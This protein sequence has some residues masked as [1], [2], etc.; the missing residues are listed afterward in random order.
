MWDS[1][2]L[3]E[4]SVKS[5]TIKI[6]ALAVVTAI[7]AACASSKPH[8]FGDSG[9][10]NPRVTPQKGERVPQHLTLQLNQGANVAVFLVVPGRGSELLFPA[11]SIQNAYVD[12]GSHIVTTRATRGML[13][14]TSRLMRMPRG[15][16]QPMGGGGRGQMNR[17]SLGLGIIGGHG[18][19]LMY[20]S[21]QAL[22]YDILKNRV[23]GLSI[24]IDDDDALSTVTKL[25]R[26][27][28][29]TTGA[30]SAYATDFP[31]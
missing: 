28:T 21:Q 14:D 9:G 12:A 15:G 24:P 31:P 25:I 2:P 5:G 10:F 6:V 16:S 7:I 3:R 30:W 22:P 19:L 11:D 20:A 17:D 13:S 8:T 23:A 26:E 29:Q 1:Q 4:G 18:Y 27:R